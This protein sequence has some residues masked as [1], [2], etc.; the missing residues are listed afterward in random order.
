MA[1]RELTHYGWDELQ[2]TETFLVS[3]EIRGAVDSILSA[4]SGTESLGTSPFL[5]RILTAG[6]VL[7][8]ELTRLIQSHGALVIVGTCSPENAT[9]VVSWE[10]S[11]WTGAEILHRGET[12]RAFSLSQGR[13]ELSLEVSPDGDSCTVTLTSRRP[14]A[15]QKRVL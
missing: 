1:G 11:A 13:Q 3:D 15:R 10:A 8:L 5:A 4:A 9:K 7:E 14:P 2:E 12:V 6:D